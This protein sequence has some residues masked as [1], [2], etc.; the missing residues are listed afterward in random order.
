M[1]PLADN[2]AEEEYLYQ[3]TVVTGIRSGAGT[4]SNIQFILSGEH[5]DTGVRKLTDGVTKMVTIL[6][7]TNNDPDMKYLATY[8]RK[9][10]SLFNDCTFIPWQ[11]V[12]V[13]NYA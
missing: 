13:E 1:S 2:L 9:F 3:I 4:A 7:N 5:Q 11:A 6:E 10:C 12:H 8:K